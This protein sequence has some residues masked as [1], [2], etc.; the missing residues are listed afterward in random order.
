M[1]NNYKILNEVLTNWDNEYKEKSDNIIS[2]DGIREELGIP[3]VIRYDWFEW[4]IFSEE[5]DSN[6]FLRHI[7]EYNSWAAIKYF[8]EKYSELESVNKQFLDK[9]RNI[10]EDQSYISAGP[11]IQYLYNDITHILDRIKFIKDNS[12]YRDPRGIYDGE[13]I[14]AV[15]LLNNLFSDPKV[16]YI[17]SSFKKD[18][19]YC[20]I[21]K[22]YYKSG[23][24]RLRI[25][26]ILESQEVNEIIGKEDWQI[27][28]GRIEK[29]ATKYN[30]NYKCF[31]WSTTEDGETVLRAYIELN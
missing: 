12:D 22:K 30:K 5:G 24:V 15:Q 21:S 25:E 19:G 17:F 7:K 20:Y 18:H 16:K 28:C 14:L 6:N 11:T 9:T 29:T 2:A 26:I 13:D 3:G 27:I 10:I 8:L 1:N 23:T 31:S 4:P